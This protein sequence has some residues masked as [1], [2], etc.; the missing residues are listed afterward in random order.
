MLRLYPRFLFARVTFE[1]KQASSRWKS[2]DCSTNT[3]NFALLPTKDIIQ[4]RLKLPVLVIAAPFYYIKK[5]RAHKAVRQISLYCLFKMEIYN[6]WSCANGPKFSHVRSFIVLFTV[7]QISSP[8]TAGE[9]SQRS[10]LS[11]VK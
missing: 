7:Y 3:P 10:I 1:E 8:S 6:R 5:R 4:K 2:S 11:I 9:P